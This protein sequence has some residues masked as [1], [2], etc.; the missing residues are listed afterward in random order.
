MSKDYRLIKN[1]KAGSEKAFDEIYYSYY[2]LVFYQAYQVLNNKDDAEDV[3]QNTFIK[4]MRGINDIDDNSNLKQLLSTIAK[5]LAIDEYRRKENIS[6][7][8]TYIENVDSIGSV[9]DRYSESEILISLRGTLEKDE[10]KVFVLKVVYDYTFK[11]IA[12]DLNVT[13][14]VVEAKYYKA[15]KKVKAYYKDR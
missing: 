10:A 3:M 6:N 4:F 7:K 11:E 14:N 9:S 2:R 15:L 12:E 13:L 8:T 1:C 5:N